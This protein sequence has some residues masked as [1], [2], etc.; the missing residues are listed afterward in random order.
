MTVLH[1]PFALK[2]IPTP[3]AL[4]ICIFPLV[5]EV[6]VTSPYNFHMDIVDIIGEKRRNRNCRWFV[7]LFKGTPGQPLTS[8]NR[9]CKQ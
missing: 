4:T 2:I 8:K 7:Y 5:G 6:I 9:V 3:L 1:I